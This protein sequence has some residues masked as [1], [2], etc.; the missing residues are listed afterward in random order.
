MNRDNDWSGRPAILRGIVIGAMLLLLVLLSPVFYVLSVGPA[1]WLS[2]HGYLS[3]ELVDWFY[4]PLNDGGQWLRD[5][6]A[7]YLPVFER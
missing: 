6:L 1:T 4:A 7:W 5:F 3:Y 2:L